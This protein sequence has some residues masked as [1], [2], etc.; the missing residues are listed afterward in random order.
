MIEENVS[1]F[2]V[3]RIDDIPLLLAFLHRMGI[4]ELLDKQ[5]RTHGN[6]AGE[7]SF[8]TVACV[9]LCYIL[10]EGDHLL[11]HVQ[12]WVERNQVMLES[13]LQQEVR[14]LDFQDD[15]LG[16][17]LDTL[18]EAKQFSEF[19]HDLNCRVVRV[20]SL[21]TKRVRVDMTT[22]KTYA[23]VNEG[24]L[25]QYG[26]SKDHRPDLAQVKLGLA[27]LYPLGLP[28]S[29]AVVSGNRGDDGIY[30]ELI[31]RVEAS[32][33]FGAKLYVGDSKMDAIAT[34]AF[35]VSGGDYYLCP[36]SL[37]QIGEI[38]LESL[39]TR[40]MESSQELKE[41]YAHKSKGGKQNRELIALGYSYEVE[42]EAEVEGHRVSW[43]EQRIVSRSV[44]FAKQQSSLLDK[45]VKRGFEALEKLNE[46]KRGKKRLNE[47]EL[48]EASQ[49]IIEKEKL[50]GLL[51][52]EVREQQCSKR[53]EE[54]QD[55]SSR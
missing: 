53:E 48:Q 13:F 24:G 26:H 33:G 23:G 3:E 49:A 37:K 54:I 39:I 1:E 42:L 29:T 55:A 4:V 9:W 45:R 43:V 31:E 46:R 47:K 11:C 10:S 27:S 6:W 16:Q 5:Y 38:E 14:G 35:L 25:F 28:V 22:S 12:E 17:M 20:Y 51:K 34:R 8:G 44:G 7:L 40:A 21:E 52:V 41:I 36:L 50:R 32:I 30:V 2:R 15:R 19:E 18:S